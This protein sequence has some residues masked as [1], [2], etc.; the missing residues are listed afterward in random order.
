MPQS[1]GVTRREFLTAVVGVAAS[2]YVIPASALGA[3]GRPAPSDRVTLGCIGLGG[4]GGADLKAFLSDDR[5][6]VTVLCDVNTGSRR[7]HGNK[8]KGLARAKQWVE[9]HEAA[10]GSGKTRG[11]FAT[12]DFR[13][14][15]SRDD[16]DA[17]CITTPDHW[18]A[19]MVTA[20]ARAGKLRWD[21]EKELFPDDPEANRMLSRAYRAPWR[22]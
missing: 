21:P 11:V 7:Y 4:R 1:G 10:K 5:A 12:Q 16:V 22:T 15:L 17:V 2:P 6:E 14:V 20:A 18:H 3:G 9:N 8:E 13:E 19:A